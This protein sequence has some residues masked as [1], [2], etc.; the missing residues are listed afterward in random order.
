MS[1]TTIPEITTSPERD[2]FLGIDWR[3]SFTHQVPKLTCIFNVK[4]ELAL[5]RR[6][7]MLPIQDIAD[8]RELTF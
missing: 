5:R 3:V 7:T 6:R 4:A 2:V 1:P 8:T